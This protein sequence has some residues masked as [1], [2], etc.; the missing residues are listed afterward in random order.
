MRPMIEEEKARRERLQK[1]REAGVDPYP[2]H[3]ERT[4]QVAEFLSAFEALGVSNTSITLVGRLRL[5]RK[6]GGLTFARLEDG[7]GNVQLAFHKDKLCEAAYESLHATADMGDFLEAICVAFTTK[8][9]E[10][11]LDVSAYRIITKVLLPLPE[12]WHGLVDVEQRFRKRY[13]DLLMNEG[14]R[15]RLRKRSAIISAIRAFMDGQAFLEVETPTLQPVYGGGFA[16]PFKTHHHAL[17][18][19]FY[20]RIS[21][22]MYLK[23]LLVGGFERVYEITK[24]FRNE[25]VDHD[26]NPEFTMFEAQIAYQN[27]RFGMDLFEELF[28]NA[29]LTIH[30]QTRMTHGDLVLDVKRPWRRMTMIEAIQEIGG[31]DVKAWKK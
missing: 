15:D 30:G 22:E 26:H 8:K 27:Y 21:D 17:D 20:L 5:I 4:H 29:A 14:I 16:K 28:E 18:A 25:G 2:S 23:R 31:V 12:K 1:L 7:S 10:R 9:G 6:H 11:S 19:D 13:L 3:V 24:V